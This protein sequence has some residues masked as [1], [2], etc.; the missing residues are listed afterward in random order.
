LILLH[1]LPNFLGIKTYPKVVAH[2]VIKVVAHKVIKVV[3]HKVIKVVAHKVIKV[4]AHKRTDIQND[5][6]NLTLK[7]LYIT[8]RL[9]P[10]A[11]G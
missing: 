5:M 8:S 9:R 2:K 4:V 3:A 1:E 11:R 7:L 6:R 10:L